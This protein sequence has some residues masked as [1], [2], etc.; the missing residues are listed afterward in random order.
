MCYFNESKKVCARIAFMAG[1]YSNANLAIEE[2]VL[3][4]IFEAYIRVKI[5]KKKNIWIYT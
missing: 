5:S 4:N 3:K 2:G 1:T